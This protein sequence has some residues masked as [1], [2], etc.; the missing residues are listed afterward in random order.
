MSQ[1]VLDRAASNVLRSKFAAGYGNVDIVFCT[2]LHAVLKA[3]W[4]VVCST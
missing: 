4:G 2:M 3:P 1:A